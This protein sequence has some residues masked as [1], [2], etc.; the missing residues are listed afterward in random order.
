MSIKENWISDI[1]KEDMRNFVENK[2]F[3]TI[4]FIAPILD[5]EYGTTYLCQTNEN[6]Q[7]YT[8]EDS[9]VLELGNFGLVSRSNGKSDCEEDFTLAITKPHLFKDYA[10]F[11]AEKNIG[12]EIDG[13]TFKVSLVESFINFASRFKRTGIHNSK[14]YSPRYNMLIDLIEDVVENIEELE[15]KNNESEMQ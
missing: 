3:A 7:E 6:M 11:V 14:N 15:E 2:M 12:K 8:N 4:N 1:N 10:L 9:F 5:E 13:K